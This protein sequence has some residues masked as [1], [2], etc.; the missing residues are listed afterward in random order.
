[1]PYGSTYGTFTSGDIVYRVGESNGHILVI[2]EAMSGNRAFKL[3]YILESDYNKIKNNVSKTTLSNALYKINI[4]NS[5]ITCG[6]DGYVNTKGKHEGIDFSYG[7]GKNIYSLTDGVITNIVEGKNGSNGLS[8]I[9][10]YNQSTNKTIIYLHANPDDKLKVGNP[11]KKGELIGTE[12][13]RG[14]STANS[15][16]THVEVRNGWQTH[17]TKSVNDYVLSN[18]NPKSFWESMGYTVK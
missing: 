2:Y 16:H 18:S 11:I 14:M 8:T 4:S 13:W 15:A 7:I 10:I 6:F 3:G 12:S 1:M 17:A 9:A 5:K